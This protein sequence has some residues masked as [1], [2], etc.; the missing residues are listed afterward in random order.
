M[1]NGP[2]PSPSFFPPSHAAVYA[3]TAEQ[4]ARRKSKSIELN[5]QAISR[6]KESAVLYRCRYL[7]RHNLNIKRGPTY[8]KINGRRYTS[9]LFLFISA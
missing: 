2:C 9:A 1:V 3:K 4:W 5:F 8:S 6:I 7:P